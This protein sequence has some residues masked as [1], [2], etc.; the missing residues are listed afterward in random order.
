MKKG[1]DD[2]QRP[3]VTDDGERLGEGALLR[4]RVWVHGRDRTGRSGSR[5]LQLASE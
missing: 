2:K 1:L 5:D 3:S 4:C